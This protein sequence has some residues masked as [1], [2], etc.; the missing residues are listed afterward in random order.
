MLA[1]GSVRAF[2]FPRHFTIAPILHSNRKSENIPGRCSIYPLPVIIVPN[3]I[4]SAI[5]SEE[6]LFV[7]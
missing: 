4:V 6:A 5:I 7:E 1:P 2:S 3:I